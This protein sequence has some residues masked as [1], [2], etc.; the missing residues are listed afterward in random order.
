MAFRG[1]LG[2]RYD[3]HAA[4]RARGRAARVLLSASSG[5]HAGKKGADDRPARGGGRSTTRGAWWA[6]QVALMGLI[7]APGQPNKTTPASRA[8]SH[9]DFPTTAQTDT[10]GFLV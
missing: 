7:T 4:T 10:T 1:W 5:P 9:G 6:L 3:H 8:V 2:E